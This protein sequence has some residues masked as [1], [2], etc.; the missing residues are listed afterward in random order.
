MWIKAFS[1]TR[2]LLLLLT[3]DEEMCGK[4]S[5]VIF[6]RSYQLEKLAVLVKSNSKC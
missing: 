2:C 5:F 4:Y 1:H 3:T 6:N